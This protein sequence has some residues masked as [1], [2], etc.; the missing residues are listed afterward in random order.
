MANTPVDGMGLDD[1]VQHILQTT[2]NKKGLE[3]SQA[4]LETPG[5]T[6]R[7]YVGPNQAI[8]IVFVPGIMGSP[9]IM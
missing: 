2:L 6:D 8:L 5:K 4:V 3:T 9:L 7:M 1:S